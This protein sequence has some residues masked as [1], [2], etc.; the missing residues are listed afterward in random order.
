MSTDW[1]GLCADLLDAYEWC[2]DKYMTAPANNDALVQRACAALAQ[3]EP[4]GPQQELESDN[5]TRQE[6]Y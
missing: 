4:Q 5:H 6:R 1:K 2:I 3:P